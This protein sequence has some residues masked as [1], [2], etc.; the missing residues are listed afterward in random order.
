MMSLQI[1][2]EMGTINLEERHIQSTM[3]V[4]CVEVLQ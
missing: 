4:V 2:M 3:H 1:T